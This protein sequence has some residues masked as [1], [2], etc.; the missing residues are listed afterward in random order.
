MTG[1]NL[2]VLIVRVGKGVEHVAAHVRIPQVNEAQARRRAHLPALL[3]LQRHKSEEC[4][5]RR[6]NANNN[7]LSYL[8][9]PLVSVFGE[10]LVGAKAAVDPAVDKG[11]GQV[12]LGRRAGAGHAVRQISLVHVVG[13]LGLLFKIAS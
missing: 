7:T 5:N 6:A 1:T 2:D 11:G 12:L 3:V 10:Q 4:A 8:V 13:R 9:D